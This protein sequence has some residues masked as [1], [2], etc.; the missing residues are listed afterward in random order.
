[1][2]WFIFYWKSIIFCTG[3][4]ED[5]V[6]YFENCSLV[7]VTCWLFDLNIMEDS[8][9]NWS[10]YSSWIWHYIFFISPPICIG[11]CC[12]KLSKE[13][14][15]NE[16]ILFWVFER[17]FSLQTEKVSFIF[18][19]QS[20]ISFLKSINSYILSKWLMKLMMNHLNYPRQW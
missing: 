18:I 2:V 19:F 20:F 15:L 4:N 12:L 10:V 14:F 5:L 3:E 9:L 13:R 8:Y 16:I 17:E 7:F 1:M 6:F 11:Y